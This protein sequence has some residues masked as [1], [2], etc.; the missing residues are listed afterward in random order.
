[1]SIISELRVRAATIADSGVYSCRCENAPVRE[2]HVA[3]KG[4]KSMRRLELIAYFREGIYCARTTDCF[5]SELR[6]IMQ[7]QSIHWHNA[8]FVARFVEVNK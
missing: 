3:V 6:Y 4:N 5:L 8:P 7:M 1:M 2:M